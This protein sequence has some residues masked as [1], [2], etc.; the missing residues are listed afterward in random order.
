MK[1][2]HMQIRYLKF[3]ELLINYVLVD[4]ANIFL[5]IGLDAKCV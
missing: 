5:L 3:C 2:I 4:E 1:E